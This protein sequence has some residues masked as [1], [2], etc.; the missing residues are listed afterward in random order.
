MILPRHRYSLSIAVCLTLGLAG[1]WPAHGADQEFLAFV[2]A[3]AA[4]AR[5]ADAPPRSLDDWVRRKAEIRSGF[6]KAWG[7]FPAAPCPLDPK[8]VGTLDRDGYR[9]ERLTFQTLPDVRMTANLYLPDSPGKHPAIL[10]VHGHWK[11]AKQDPVVQARCI[12]AAKLGF[13]VLAV[14]AFGAGERGVGKAL[15]EYHGGMTAATL[16]PVGLPLSGIQKYENSRAIDYLMTRPEVDGDKIGV[17]GA[18]GGGNQTMYV[19]AWDERVKAAVPVCSVGNYQAYLGAGCC[20]CEVVPGALAFTEESSVLGAVAPRAL[21]VVNATEDAR[22]FSVAEAKVSLGQAAPVYEAFGKADRLRHAVF[23]SKHDYSK[24]MRETA[25][26]WFTRHL[27]GEGDGSPVSEPE[28]KP[29]DPE[30]LR[31]YPGEGRPDDFMTL[32]KFAA[33]EGRARIAGRPKVDDRAGWEGRRKSLRT[34]LVGPVFGN[35][36]PVPM[37]PTSADAGGTA[38]NVTFAPEPG[39]TLSAR[40]EPATKAGAGTV[41]LIDLDGAEHARAGMLAGEIRKAGMGLVTLDLRATGA[42]AFPSDR[43]GTAP[44]HNTA[45]WGLWIGRPL[46]GQWV[47]DVTRTIDA[48]RPEVSRNLTLIGE[49]PGGV[50]AIAAAAVD[51]RVTRVAAVGPLASFISDAPYVGQRLG[52]MAPGILEKVGDVADLASM[53][54]PRRLVITGAVDGGGK[55]LSRDA[56]SEAFAGT[57]RVYGLLESEDAFTADEAR[58][59][60]GVVAAVGGVR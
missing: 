44:D 41:L 2:R 5:K 19:A 43:I 20:V 16:L 12:G 4:E 13:V 6:D 49:G 51:G 26:G 50:V 3:R 56:L 27:K 57:A 8:L 35:P 53:I 54:A 32:P 23:V 15:G 25:Y 10:A 37:T 58:P 11:G 31:C 39:I 42:L 30:A 52:L 24:P 34:A 28:I 40:V 47:V 45:E 17:T 33:R 9:I 18:S 14:D 36:G 60:A 55:V 46:L 38:E 59:A 7:T 48:L 29:E 21:L 22:Q 1:A